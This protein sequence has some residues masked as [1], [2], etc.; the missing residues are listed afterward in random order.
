MFV[1]F[2]T[3]TTGF[4]E[5][6]IVE[7]ASIIILDN[8]ER[9]QFR[10]LMKPEF[11]IH[12]KASEVHGI[13]NEEVA[14]LPSSKKVVTDWLTYV[15]SIAEKHQETEIIFGAHNLPFD[16]N[17]ISRHVSLESEKKL[18]SLKLAKSLSLNA[19]NNKLG[20]L[21]EYFGFTEKY[22]AHSALDD[23]LMTEKVMFKLF[24]HAG[25]DYYEE[26]KYQHSKI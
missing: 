23:C 12:P 6:D 16:V 11:P 3:E 22:Q 7:L 9:H 17:M 24:E 18:C 4:G 19:P 25:R 13:S 5:A 26:A 8:G 14:N 15:K 1:I 21:Y 2:D 20:T 10:Q